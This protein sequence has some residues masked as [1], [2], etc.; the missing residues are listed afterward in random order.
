MTDEIKA[1]VLLVDDE[2]QF[3]EALSRRLAGRGM[4]VEAAADGE[5]ALRQARGKEY[6]A[7]LL[8]LVMPGLDGLEVLKQ[9][10]QENPDLQ[11]IIL[12]GH[13]TVEKGIEAIREGAVELLEKPVD[14]DK[15]LRRI[16]E[17]Q[18]QRVLLVEKRAEERVKD[19]LKSKG[20]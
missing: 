8:D 9:L 6:D 17:A 7:I 15:L 4:K 18:R 11:I 14:M 3:V 10:R 12:T 1:K 13:A 20:W 2:D 16:G 5:A 19:I